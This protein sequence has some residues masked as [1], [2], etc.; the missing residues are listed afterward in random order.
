MDLYASGRLFGLGSNSAAVVLSSASV[1]CDMDSSAAL[2]TIALVDSSNC[3]FDAGSQ[4]LV[5]DG[6]SSTESCYGFWHFAPGGLLL[7]VSLRP[8]F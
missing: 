2:G 6:S 3:V 4:F 7:V 5:D 1:P 8:R